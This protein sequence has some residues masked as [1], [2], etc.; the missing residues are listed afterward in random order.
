MCAKKEV[1]IKNIKKY[2]KVVAGVVFVGVVVKKICT[3]V[4]AFVKKYKSY[5]EEETIEDIF[6]EE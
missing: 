2:T 6:V 1:I 3:D 5:D 4:I